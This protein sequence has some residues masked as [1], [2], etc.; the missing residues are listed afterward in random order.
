MV[1]SFIESML[2]SIGHKFIFISC[3]HCITFKVS[4]L[5]PQ[6]QFMFSSCSPLNVH[7]DLHL[8]TLSRWAIF[9][10]IFIFILLYLCLF[11]WNGCLVGVKWGC[12]NITEKKKKTF[13]AGLWII[14]M[15]NWYFFEY[16]FY[17][18]I[19]WL[20]WLEF[21]ATAIC[22]EVKSWKCSG[23]NLVN[24]PPCLM[25]RKCEGH[26]LYVF[27][28]EFVFAWG[29]SLSITVT[30]SPL[31][32]PWIHMNCIYETWQDY[33]DWNQDA[34]F[35]S[36]ILPVSPPPSTCSSVTPFLWLMQYWC[37]GL[38]HAYIRH[39]TLVFL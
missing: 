14:M 28:L 7:H 9:S 10:T 12:E 18:A 34:C 36:S 11:C 24:W 1:W 6:Y 19:H 33:I 13:F 22:A 37:Q 30:Y 17:P 35:Y 25:K 4:I 21:N 2:Y 31:N 38:F 3:I 39:A 15:W 32:T 8:W 20:I 29:R 27:R 5:N 23:A 16:F 26:L